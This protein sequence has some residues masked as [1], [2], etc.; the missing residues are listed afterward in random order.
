MESYSEYS[1]LLQ[2]FTASPLGLTDKSDGS[3]RRIHYLSFP[4]N[5]LFSINSGI[6]ECYGTITYSRISDAT[7]A[8]LRFRRGSILVKRDFE[9][10]FWHVPIAPDDQPILGFEWKDKY[11]AEQFLP[12]GLRT[13][14][15]LFN[16]FA[17]TFY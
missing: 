8:V 16:L 13:A 17:E 10:A 5:D 1:S 2:R 11:Y 9:S 15:Y 12:F 6:P 7:S 4:T 14:S 3:K